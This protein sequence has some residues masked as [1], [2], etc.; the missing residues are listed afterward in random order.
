MCARALQCG[1][2]KTLTARSKARNKGG[3]ASD[4]TRVSRLCRA[5]SNSSTYP[6][7]AS[8]IPGEDV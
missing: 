3:D 8:T 4:W 2:Y 6:C 5:K 7:E 1:I